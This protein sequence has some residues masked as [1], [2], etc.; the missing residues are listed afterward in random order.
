MDNK[1]KKHISIAVCG[2]VDSGKSTTTGR[3]IWELKGIPD[4]EMKKL[5]EIAKQL[6][7][8]SFSFAFYMDTQKEERERGITIKATTKEFFTDTKHY[9]IVD[10]PGHKDYIKNMVSGSS[11]TDI[12]LLLV[13][14]DGNFGTAIQGQSKQHA[15][16][17]YLLGIK[18][19]II[20]I[21]KMDDPNTAKFSKERYEEIKNEMANI[22]SK[23]G[24]SKDF[25]SKSVA[26][27]PYS[28][29][30]GDNLTKKSDKMPWWNGMDIT[31]KSGKNVHV[32]T[33]LDCLEHGVE[34][35][36]RKTTGNLRIPVSGVFNFKGVGDV[37]T[38][39][40][41][42]GTISKDTEVIFLPSHTATNPCTGKIFSIE[43]HHKQIPSASA[44]DN[45]G[46]NIKGLDKNNMPKIGDIMVLKSDKTIG[47]PKKIVAQ[48]QVLSH[49]GELK[50]GYT[51]IGCVR[52][53]KAPIKL[54]A[55]NWLMNK[56][57]GKN[58]VPNPPFV[59]ANDTAE[60]VFEPQFPLVVQ[61]FKECDGLSRLA[62]FEGT[63]VV[64]LGKVISVE[65]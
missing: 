42:Q 39:R 35:P 29:W 51:P 5:E 37:I 58:K 52:T 63:G 47:I 64:M 15:L 36:E 56:Q 14:A 23:V 17:A 38:G 21:N 59:K 26:F 50:V 65:Y 9:T 57:S 60:L 61:P 1:D 7:K 30:Y 8:E 44:G 2:H 22:L 20:G 31:T 33:I 46:M 12:F 34:I 13:P 27:I 18:Q 10:A 55:I 53:A 16:L 19:I 40:I 24:Y 4:R 45:V 49:P 11:Q 28:G 48:V 62:V 41:E 43:M 54:V 3:L 25:V 32:T 6:G